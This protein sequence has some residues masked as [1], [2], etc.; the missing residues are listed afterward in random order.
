MS[1]IKRG[2]FTTDASLMVVF[3]LLNLK[4]KINDEFDWWVYDEDAVIEINV[5]NVSF[6]NLHTDGP[7]DIELI[8]EPDGLNY[9]QSLSLKSGNIF[10]GA[11]EEITSESEEP[12]CTRGGF[13]YETSPGNYLLHA[14]LNGRTISLCLEPSTQSTQLNCFQSIPSLEGS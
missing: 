9:I 14:N 7:Y 4:H 13:F 11:V 2:R 1:V 6:L 3:D 8:N 5:A 10:I 12:D